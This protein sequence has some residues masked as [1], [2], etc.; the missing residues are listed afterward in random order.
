MPVKQV[1]SGVFQVQTIA[2][3]YYAAD[4]HLI[5]DAAFSRKPRK[6]LEGLKGAGYR[7][8][9]I[10]TIVVTHGHP[11]HIGG[12]A[13]LR[14]ATQAKVCALDEERKYVD[15]T[16]SLPTR[17]VLARLLMPLMRSRPTPVDRLLHEG[18]RV[19]AFQVIATPGHTPGH[20]SLSDPARSL[21][22]AGDAVRVT[23]DYVGPSPPRLNFDHPQALESFRKLARLDFE[24][25]VAGH[26]QTV[27]G[28]ASARLRASPFFSAPPPTPGS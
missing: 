17:G 28:G 19:G 4:D 12:L 9:D 7:P 5:V 24:N 10:S 26:G 22:I 13:A 3:S 11:D 27:M 16:A 25:L 8:T 2:F 1:L 21:V 20:L 14:E 15:G 23:T 18:E 6:I